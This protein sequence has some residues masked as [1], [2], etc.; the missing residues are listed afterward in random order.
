M[1][2][3]IRTYLLSVVLAGIFFGTTV[4]LSGQMDVIESQPQFLFPDFRD[5]RI[6]IKSGKIQ[7]LK[8]NY[9]TLSGTMVYVSD[10]NIYD[11]TSLGIVDTIFIQ[12]RKFVP[13]GKA[14]LEVLKGGDLS[15]Y[16]Q[17]KS[18]LQPVGK[19]AGYGSKSQASA[20]TTYS[21]ISTSGANYNLKIPPDYI[22]NTR[23]IYWIN[24][25]DNFETE[26]QLLK[27]FSEQ[28]EALK[29]YIRKNRLKFD[30]CEHVIEMVRYCAELI[31]EKNN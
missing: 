9:N 18:D 23:T 1:K 3:S 7:N 12:D 21:N 11:L 29:A 5:S 2:R 15:L 31:A 27:L 16:C 6:L 22:I 8:M 19:D 25:A 26:R 13:V 28:A 20:T 24:K 14:F 10:N 30:N 4:T 17:V